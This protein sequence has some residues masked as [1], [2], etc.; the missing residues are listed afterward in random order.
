MSG[1]APSGA[2]HGPSLTARIIWLAVTVALI[3]SVLSGLAAARWVLASER[4]AVNSA[5]DSDEVVTLRTL[6]QARSL[7]PTRRVARAVVAAVVVGGVA[8]FA[9]GAGAARLITG[10]L[11]RTAATARALGSG[12]RD[13]RAPVDGPPEVADVATSLNGLAEAL[14]GSEERQHRFLLGVSHELRTPLTAVQGFAESIADGVVTGDEAQQAGRVIQAEAQRLERLVADLLALARLE[15]DDF[16]LDST[17]VDVHDLVLGTG[18]VWESRA[19]VPVRV[20]DQLGAPLTLRTD[21]GRLRQVLD[22]LLA[23]ATRVTPDG[24][25]VV[26]AMRT[27]A[28]EVIIQVRDSGPGLSPEDRAV[29]FTPGALGA[30]YQDERPIG[31]GIGLSLVHGL[32]TRLGG[33]ID[34]GVAP[35]GGATFTVRLPS[36]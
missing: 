1:P 9:V 30:R 33:T 15:A 13:V 7:R 20:E 19:T 17:D 31:V 3:S 32:V 21:A 2:R 29:A 18:Q 28:G 11:R 26:L 23:N 22:G 27:G 5:V 25:V 8:G 34:V 10:P 36:G 4:A 14:A 12:R 6:R 35:E 24:G 16:R